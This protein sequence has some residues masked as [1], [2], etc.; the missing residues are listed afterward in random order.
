MAKKNE[1]QYRSE[2]IYIISPYKLH[3]LQA[4]LPKNNVKLK[5]ERSFILQFHLLQG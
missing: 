4:K 2:K 1:Q 5:L 3:S